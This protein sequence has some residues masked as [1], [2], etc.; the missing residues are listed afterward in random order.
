MLF[1]PWVQNPEPTSQKRTS[2]KHEERAGVRL[3]LGS[4]GGCWSVFQKLK[5]C[6]LGTWDIWWVGISY[7]TRGGVSEDLDEEQRAA[8]AQLFQDSLAMV[9][10][11]P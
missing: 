7:V 4:S 2:M 11:A 8:K 10:A 5:L 9:L 1:P 3:L 6:Y